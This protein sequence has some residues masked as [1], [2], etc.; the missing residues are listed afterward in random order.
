MIPSLNHYGLNLADLAAQVADESKHSHRN[1]VLNE[2]LL[3]VRGFAKLEVAEIEK[4]LAASPLAVLSAWE[5]TEAADALR[6]HHM[7]EAEFLR[8]FSNLD[9]LERMVYVGCSNLS[10]NAP[11]WQGVMT[12]MRR[13]PWDALLFLQHVV[14]WARRFAHH[15]PGDVRGFTKINHQ[16]PFAVA[17]KDSNVSGHELLVFDVI[18]DLGIVVHQAG[19]DIPATDLWEWVGETL[20]L[21]VHKLSAQQKQ[22]DFREAGNTENSL[23]VV[24]AM[25]GVD[26]YD[27]RGTFGTDLGLIIDIGDREVTIPSTA[28][29]EQHVIRVINTMTPLSAERVGGSLQLCWYDTSISEKDLARIIH[30]ALKQAFILSTVSVNMIFDPL[31]ISSLKPSVLAY[32]ES[33]DTQLERRTEEGEPFVICTACKSYA[34]HAFCIASADFPPCCGRSYDELA[35]LAQ[36][37][38]GLKQVTIKK[39]ICLSRQKGAYIGVDKAAA[40][41]SEGYITNLCLHSIRDNPHPTTA[42][43]ECIAYYIDDFDMIAVLSKDFAGRS[44][45]GKTFDSLLQ[46][47]A[48]RQ[49]AGYVGLS[50]AYI[51]SPKFLSHDGGLSRVGWMNNSLKTRLK[52]RAEHIAT[53]VDCINIG[54]L[55]DFLATWRR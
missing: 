42:I 22:L 10:E 38:R 14:R 44:P 4:K 16:Y 23:F 12:M 21:F 53:E 11:E 9:L 26:G 33:R 40:V 1:L 46:R 7:T 34:P 17:I 24:R 2:N 30:E 29:I 32:I 19:A 50:E 28:Y 20:E 48:G 18:A 47:V 43:P 54:G 8:Q 15:K 49:A 35:A 36:L 5:L 27:V 31:R 52:I 41:S 13:G 25:G 6:E 45:D 3:D 55:K 51:L 37:T 39:G